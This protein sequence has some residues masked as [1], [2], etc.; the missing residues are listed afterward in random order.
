MNRLAC[1]SVW[2]KKYERLEESLGSFIF[3]THF[4]GLNVLVPF[5]HNYE[6]T[7]PYKCQLAVKKTRLKTTALRTVFLFVS[8]PI[9]IAENLILM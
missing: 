9:I 1:S 8:A 4:I 3:L 6:S 7:L 5:R 2:G